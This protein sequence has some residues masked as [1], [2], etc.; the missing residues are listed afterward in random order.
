M[1]FWTPASRTSIPRVSVAIG[2]ALKEDTDD[3]DILHVLGGQAALVTRLMN[4]REMLKTP[5]GHAAAMKEL[6]AMVERNAWK[7]EPQPIASIGED[8]V[9]VKLHWNL[10]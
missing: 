2:T 10:L 5:E 6:T 4:T 8:D 1:A 7:R 9:V 3:V